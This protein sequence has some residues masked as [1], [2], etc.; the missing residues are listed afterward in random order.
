MVAVS[1]P[2][3]ALLLQLLDFSNVTACTVI[4][5]GISSKAAAVHTGPSNQRQHRNGN[6]ADSQMDAQAA[7]DVHA[8]IFAAFTE[9]TDEAFE[10]LMAAL[11]PQS[12]D[13]SGQRDLPPRLDIAHPETGATVRSI[14]VLLMSRVHLCHVIVWSASA[15]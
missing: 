5:N 6:G 7:A 12:D 3:N 9:N 4:Q 14:S 2:I 11:Q 13:E 10:Q 1:Q 8:A 15:G